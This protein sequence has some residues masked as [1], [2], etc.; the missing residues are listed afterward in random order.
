MPQ[1]E[2]GAFIINGD[3]GTGA[4]MTIARLAVI[5]NHQPLITSIYSD[6]LCTGLPQ[7]RRCSRPGPW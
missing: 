4:G 3:P 1:V 2:P 5:P 7:A 6:Q